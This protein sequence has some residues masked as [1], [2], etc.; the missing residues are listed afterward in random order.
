M[1]RELPLRQKRRRSS[2]SSGVGVQNENRI[3]STSP[4]DSSLLYSSH[5]SDHRRS[6]SG[7]DYSPLSSMGQRGS[8]PYVQ[9]TSVEAEQ[10]LQEARHPTQGGEGQARMQYV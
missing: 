5:S 9:E 7:R 4:R 10:G 6:D 3:L 2:H 8:P 1:E